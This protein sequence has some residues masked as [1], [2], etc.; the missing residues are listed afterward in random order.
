[1]A[2]EITKLCVIP[3]YY[4]PL[5]IR[6]MVNGPVIKPSKFTMT[7]IRALV[8]A[9]IKIY[10]VN[11]HNKKERVRLTFNNLNEE[12]FQPVKRERVI[13]PDNIVSSP[14]VATSIEK[15]QPS[16]IASRRAGKK[17]PP[18][19]DSTTM[20]ITSFQAPLKKSANIDDVST[21]DFF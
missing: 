9:N 4:H 12:H 1:M 17:E 8:A 3:D 21:P 19:N 2:T 20:Q 18:K 11:P 7:E 10:E 16:I 6:G 5:P 13:R 15:K 14:V